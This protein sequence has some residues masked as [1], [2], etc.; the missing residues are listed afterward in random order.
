MMVRS[1]MLL[2]LAAALA[3]GS[4]VAVPEASP[5]AVATPVADPVPAASPEQPA[6]AAPVLAA[7][8]VKQEV[9]EEVAKVQEVADAVAAKPQGRSFDDEIFA[10]NN[11]VAKVKPVQADTTSGEEQ[12]LRKLNTRCAQKDT[13][14]CVLLKMVT[15]FNRLLKKSS[16]AIGETVEIERTTAVTV[17]E[18]A[19]S[20]RALEGDTDEDKLTSLMTDKLFN[21]VRSRSMRLKLLP[22]ADLL[23]TP[24]TEKDG[25]LNLDMSLQANK[26]EG[27]GNKAQKAIVPA[28]I[29][30]GAVKIGMLGILAMKALVLLVG[31]A[32]ILSKI[33][34]L[35][36]VVIGLKKLFS[37]QRHVTY[38]VVAQPHHG[39]SSHDSHD[40]YSSGW[41]RA[42]RALGDLPPPHGDPQ[43]LAYRAHH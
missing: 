35:L 39:H 33:A 25:G 18:E 2:L 22:G 24:K 14:S 6:A 21:F 3:A 1:A 11:D 4:P 37:Q 19:G 36:A 27:R 7:E 10:N 43:E 9:V 8:P 12:L 5:A 17:S 38:E 34:F 20:K 13:S 15:Y 23:V 42:A 40:S 32:L 30:A 41:G 16:I 31:K 28:L 29:A 26:D